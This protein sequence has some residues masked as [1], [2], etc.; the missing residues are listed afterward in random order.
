[1]PYGT[2]GGFKFV[3]K[4][5]ATGRGADAIYVASSVDEIK[6]MLDG[7]FGYPVSKST[8]FYMNRNNLT[9]A[10]RG[11]LKHCI[12]QR[13][14]IPPHWNGNRFELLNVI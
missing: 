14:A 12:I 1:M 10:K 8:L 6:T 4:V 2:Q 9:S 7:Y 13:A 3:Y 5:T 11:M